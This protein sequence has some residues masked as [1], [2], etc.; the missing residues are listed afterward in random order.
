MIGLQP[1]SGSMIRNEQHSSG[2]FKRQGNALLETA[3]FGAV[4]IGV[5][6]FFL[7]TLSLEFGAIKARQQAFRLCLAHAGDDNGSYPYEPRAVSGF[8]QDAVP[9][10]SLGSWETSSTDKRAGCYAEWGQQLTMGVSPSP[11]NC[12]RDPGAPFWFGYSGDQVGRFYGHCGPGNPI[13]R[14]G[15]IESFTSSTAHQHTVADAV[16]TTRGSV[17]LDNETKL[18]TTLL[19]G[20]Q[21]GHTVTYGGEVR[22]H[23]DVRAKNPLK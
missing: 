14:S 5:L 2:W 18:S 21:I 20:A 13:D 19:S 7:R 15:H 6:G 22:G 23:T 17:S 8:V 9:Q 10:P 4:A 12:A 16:G 3:I 11:M 1:A